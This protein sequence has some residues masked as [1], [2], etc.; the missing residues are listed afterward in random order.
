MKG[1]PILSDGASRYRRILAD[2]PHL[3][4][5]VEQSAVCG[6]DPL[7][8]TCRYVL[9]PA[10]GG[11]V[12]WLLAQAVRHGH[13]RLYFLARDGY[14]PCQAARLFCQALS[15]PVDCRYLS[16]S[17]Y[18]LR[19]PLFHLKHGEALD[20]VCRAGLHVTPDI[21]LSRAGLLPAEREEVLGR[22][23]LSYKK[24]DPIPSAA[25][26]GIRGALGRCPLFLTYLDRHSRK[27]LPGLAGYLRQEGLFEKGAYALVDSGWAGSMQKTLRDAL[28]HFG[29]TAR[30]EGYYWGL[31]RLPG[32]VCPADYHCYFFGPEGRLKEKAFF[33]NNLFEA[34]FSAPHGM[35]LSYR[36]EGDRFLPCY[37][38]SETAR[39][40]FLQ[41]LGSLLLEG[42]RPMVRLAQETGLQGADIERDRRTVARLLKEFMTAPTRAQAELF[43]SLPFSD[44]VLDGG[45]QPLAPLLTDEELKRGHLL[46]KLL[47]IAGFPRRPARESAWY[48]GSVAR[49]GIR[50][51]GHLRSY[52]RYQYLRHLNPLGRALAKRR[53]KA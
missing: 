23:P 35:T 7:A 25:L 24:D 52:T 6:D 13:T 29:R 9:T 27:A 10:L 37:G 20:Y 26:P 43:G 47:S 45:D 22:L 12:Q 8:Q 1:R 11:F 5:A 4:A 15:L 21:L 53:E 34:V 51:K 3:Q 36:Q 40:E 17:R 19:L 39:E 50:G 30:L 14:F 28:T 49:L 16:C 41:R 2:N 33:N 38:R 44:D 18:S 42:I 31:Y 46:P 48:P 32:G